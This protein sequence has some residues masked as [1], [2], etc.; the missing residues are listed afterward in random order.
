MVHGAGE[1]GCAWGCEG[2]GD[3]VVW[4]WQKKDERARGD[5]MSSRPVFLA[6]A[7]PS[8][9]PH[10]QSIVGVVI[11]VAAVGEVVGVVVV[12]GLAVEET[13]V[14]HLTATTPHTYIR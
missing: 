5:P 12:L 13:G 9:S 1:W 3:G 8:P 11:V 2:S 4:R 7:R 14:A 6:H 10:A